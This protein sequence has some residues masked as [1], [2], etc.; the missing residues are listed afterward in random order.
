LPGRAAAVA[1]PAAFPR[2]PAAAPGRHVPGSPA[3]RAVAGAD[4]RL[5]R[6]PRPQHRAARLSQGRTGPDPRRRSV[7]GGPPA[8][9][10]P[11]VTYPVEK[12][13]TGRQGPVGG[14]RQHTPGRRRATTPRFRSTAGHR[15]R[16]RSRRVCHNPPPAG[17]HDAAT[18]SAPF[19][20]VINRNGRLLNTAA[21]E[22]IE[23]DFFLWGARRID[24]VTE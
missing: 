24:L 3:D 13:L 2:R 11:C 7:R 6:R 23:R 16:T 8:P 18:G 4:R 22:M 12:V 21:G 9:L 20:K 1:V 17:T 15:G 10:G 14:C 19:R 5:L